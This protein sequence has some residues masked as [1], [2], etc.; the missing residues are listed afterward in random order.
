MI[1]FIYYRNV[2]E[3]IRIQNRTTAMCTISNAY[4]LECY[5]IIPSTISIMNLKPRSLT[6]INRSL[7]GY[8]RE[9]RTS[10]ARHP[11]PP[12]N[13][14]TRTYDDVHTNS[15]CKY[16]TTTSS[17]TP[18][19]YSDITHTHVHTNK[20]DAFNPISLQPHTHAR[21]VCVSEL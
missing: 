14:H 15:V 3:I 5:L 9:F 12:Q 7:S 1:L 21:R 6:Y 17:S 10:F 20:R 13:I 2:K 16:N 8:L 4:K 11:N 18:N 19:A